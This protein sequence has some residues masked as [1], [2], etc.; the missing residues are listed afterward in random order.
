MAAGQGFLLGTNPPMLQTTG[1]AAPGMGPL[2]PLLRT[3]RETCI[4][5]GFLLSGHPK[6]F[7]IKQHWHKRKDITGLFKK[8]EK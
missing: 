2:C 8:N 4:Y 1:I 5:L 7:R 3:A 6:G